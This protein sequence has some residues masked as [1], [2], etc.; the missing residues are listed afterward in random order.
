MPGAD[1]DATVELDAAKIAPQVTWGTNPGMVTSVTGPRA[2][3]GFV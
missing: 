1:F 3:S 2:G